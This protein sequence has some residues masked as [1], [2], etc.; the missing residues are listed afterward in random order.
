MLFSEFIDATGAPDN[1]ITYTVYAGLNRIYMRHD[2]YTK[3]EVYKDGARILEDLEQAAAVRRIVPKNA[4][5]HGLNK[6]FTYECSHCRFTV[7]EDDYFCRMCGSEFMKDG[8]RNGDVSK[9]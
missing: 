8:I 9:D 4:F 6:P 2:D 3:A 7:S 5:Y 1:M